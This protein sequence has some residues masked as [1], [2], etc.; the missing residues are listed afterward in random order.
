MTC[1]L[2]L[3]QSFFQANSGVN[4][5]LDTEFEIPPAEKG[6]FEWLN[7]INSISKE[8]SDPRQAIYG[9]VNLAMCEDFAQTDYLEQYAGRLFAKMNISDRELANFASVSSSSPQDWR[10][11]AVSFA[12]ARRGSPFIDPRNAISSEKIVRLYFQALTAAKKKEEVFLFFKEVSETNNRSDQENNFETAA[13][14]EENQ[15]REK[16]ILFLFE[17]MKEQLQP[18][19]AEQVSW[20]ISCYYA[21]PSGIPVTRKSQRNTLTSDQV[22]N[23]TRRMTPPVKEKILAVLD[24]VF[25]KTDSK[26]NYHDYDLLLLWLGMSRVDVEQDPF[27]KNK[28]IARIANLLG[29]EPSTESDFP[30][31]FISAY[32]DTLD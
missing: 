15:E 26:Y 31:K 21:S 24:E 8:Y 23:I 22:N 9:I 6:N 2:H 28:F 5:F 14:Q 18:S 27:W 32:S 4:P 17:Q 20:L 1:Q 11:R 16:I 29:V 13:E 3:A 10:N 7:L 25:Q 30:Q 12:L 19:D